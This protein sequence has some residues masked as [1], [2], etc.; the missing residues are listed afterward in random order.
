MV[1]M[2][3][4]LASCGDA[5]REEDPVDTLPE[6]PAV[7]SSSYADSV[8]A[9]FVRQ[10]DSVLSRMRPELAPDDVR[11][12][13][14]LLERSEGESKLRFVAY[15]IGQGSRSVPPLTTLISTTD[16]WNTLVAA[17]Q[18]LGKLGTDEVVEV[19]AARLNHENSWVR[20]AAAHALGDIGG[21]AASQALVS[22]LKDTAETVVSAALI[23]LGKAGDRRAIPSV[24]EML[25]HENARVRSGAVS[26]IGRLG[27]EEDA[28]VLAPLLDDPD[29]GVRFKAQQA[30]DRIRS[31]DRGR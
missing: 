17:I 1:L 20:M 27:A 28:E 9:A 8:H 31:G 14:V 21:T 19:I 2:L 4:V 30:M 23:G 16:D 10:P 13:A 7:W 12:A 18:T 29:A 5:A 25:V 24:R 22:T 6:K 3:A 15:L 26:A 11:I